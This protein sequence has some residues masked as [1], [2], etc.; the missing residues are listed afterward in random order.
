MNFE[1]EFRQIGEV[2][3]SEIKRLI[4]ELKPE[5]WNENSIRQNVYDVHA[6]TETINLA[7]DSDF[8][9]VNPTRHPM[10][11]TF[12][13]PLRPMFQ[14]IADY[15]ENSVRWQDYFRKN[16]HGYFIRA[17]IVKLIAG[18]KIKEHRDKNFSLA[19]S[20]R[21]HIPIITN[22]KVI[23]NIGDLSMNMLEG[24]VIEI[25]NRMNHSVVNDSQQDRVHLILDW[26]VPGEPCCCADKTHPGIPCS[27]QACLETDRLKIACHCFSHTLPAQ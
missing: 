3:V 2:D 17:N 18:G 1:S 9:H 16:G 5:S 26:V 4:N 27:P 6:D 24:E 22:D 25:N 20:H 10:L 19:H 14:L 15:Y 11:Q 7:W 12:A 8:R 23:F 21:I 13:E